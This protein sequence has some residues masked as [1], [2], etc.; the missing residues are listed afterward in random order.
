MRV[1]CVVLI[2]SLGN[3]FSAPHSPYSG[4]ETRSIKALSEA[5]IASYLEGNGMGYAKAAELNSYPGPKHVLELAG[6][7]GLSNDQLTQ[8]RKLFE[9][10]QMEAK[11]LGELLIEQ[12]RELDR[13][14]ATGAITSP[15]LENRTAEI[16]L[17]EAQI[18]YTHLNTHL[19]QKLLLSA[20]QIEQYDAL[21]G[22]LHGG[23]HRDH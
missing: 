6:E 3:A 11:R 7:L 13:L 23:H 4:E 8:T 19:A 17:L 20:N 5:E 2:I 22:Y 15:V 16:A 9:Q 12:E 14:F 1:L 10:M 21:R 18:R